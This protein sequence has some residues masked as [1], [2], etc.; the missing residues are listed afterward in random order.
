MGGKELRIGPGLET[1][2]VLF[3]LIFSVLIYVAFFFH[4][5][6][7]SQKN[8]YVFRQKVPSFNIIFTE[9]N[10]NTPLRKRTFLSS[11]IS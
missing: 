5:F 11:T 10:T 3:I 4:F 2:Y 8:L 9:Q 1:I 7:L 6:I